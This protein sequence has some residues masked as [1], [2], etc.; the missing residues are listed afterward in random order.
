MDVYIQGDSKNKV[1]DFVDDI[2]GSGPSPAF[3]R[4]LSDKVDSLVNRIKQDTALDLTGLVEYS[5]P[6]EPV[7]FE[8]CPHTLADHI[9][10]SNKRKR[11]EK[12][13]MQD[14]DNQKEDNDTCKEPAIKKQKQE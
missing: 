8:D 12:T 13:T 11:K 9:I 7:S 6:I 14:H 10:K 2:I 3:E 1:C 5:F 4:C